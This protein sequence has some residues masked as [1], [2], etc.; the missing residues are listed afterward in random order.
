MDRFIELHKSSPGPKGRFMHTGMEVFFRRLAESF[1]PR[2][3]FHLAFIEVQGQ[4]AA[5]AVGFAFKN[6]LSLYNS[7]FDHKFGRL[8]PGMVL[9]SDLIRRAVAAGRE[10]F[11]MLK[12]D[13]EY[14]YRFGAVPREIGKLVLTRG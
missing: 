3:V 13:L 14:K 10:R 9:L 4:K 6:T 8:S 5:G 12:G 2:H 7:A 1:L 11:D